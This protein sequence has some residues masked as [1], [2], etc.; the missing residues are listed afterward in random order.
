VRLGID[1][2]SPLCVQ[3][4]DGVIAVNY[5]ARGYGIS[6]HD[7]VDTVKEKCPSCVLVHVET[8]GFQDQH[9]QEKDNSNVSEH[10]H[11]KSETKVS[12]DRYRDASSRIFKVL[13]S[14]V[15][16]CEKASI[17]EAY[18]DVSEEVRAIINSKKDQQ[19]FI[20]FIFDQLKMDTEERAYYFETK[21]QPFGEV[22]AQIPESLLIGCAFAAKIRYAIYSQF[23]YT[24]SAGIAENKLLAKLGS[25]MH[26]P[27]QQ[28]LISP[29][30]VPYLLESLPLK[31]LRS[32][33]GK[34]GTLIEEKTNARTAKEAQSITLEEWNEIVGRDTAEWIYNLV[35]GIDYSPVNAREITKSILAAKT[36]KAE[37]SW[38][39]LEKWIKLLAY[40]LCERLSKDQAMNSRRPA[41]LVIHYSS[42]GHPSCS[43]SIPFPCGKD[44]VHLL[45]QN[46]MKLLKTAKNFRFPCSRLSLSVSRFHS[47]TSEAN[48]ISTFLR[49]EEGRH[50]NDVP[51]ESIQVPSVIG[52][53]ENSLEKSISKLNDG[54]LE[55]YSDI[56]SEPGENED[57]ILAK[58]LQEEEWSKLRNT[59]IHANDDERRIKRKKK[60]QLQ[61]L[62]HFFRPSPEE[63]RS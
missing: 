20:E 18:L 5:A 32:L 35:R 54:P 37:S 40:E 52:L 9:F 46:A 50:T 8:V 15:D 22:D 58:R 47:I 30:S 16:R 49:V 34:L 57:Y 1:P 7:R 2:A 12:L 6:R 29:Q 53:P 39:G 42:V 19:N 14:F 48:S 60:G 28:T 62:D 44:K 11:R 4:W 38:E 26:K 63:K 36:F 27:S 55:K 59:K 21:F 25:S 13:S 3:Q 24:S 17:D 23:H 43:K 51:S 45:T 41:N 56:K 33:G 61:T 31:K 10:S